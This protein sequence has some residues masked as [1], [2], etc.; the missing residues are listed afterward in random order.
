MYWY[1][2]TE[3]HW[4]CS[5]RRNPASLVRNVVCAK[6]KCLLHSLLRI[7]HEHCTHSERVTAVVLPSPLKLTS[8]LIITQDISPIRAAIPVV[9]F[10]LQELE[11]VQRGP[12]WGWMAPWK[13]KGVGDIVASV[14]PPDFTELKWYQNLKFDSG[15]TIAIIMRI[16]RRSTV[17]LLPSSDLPLF[18]LSQGHCWS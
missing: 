17:C 11:M 1:A 10:H 14:G 9:V 8:L 3:A 6:D 7:F 4:L 18:L 13:F 5:A 2:R 15:Y 16:S 12:R